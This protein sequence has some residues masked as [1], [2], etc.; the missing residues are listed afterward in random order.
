MSSN[1]FTEL[2][3]QEKAKIKAVEEKINFEQSVKAVRGLFN[4]AKKIDS[5]L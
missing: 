1:Q 5:S 3:K 2:V 4:A